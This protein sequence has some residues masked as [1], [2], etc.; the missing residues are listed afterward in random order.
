MAA[1]QH[2]LAENLLKSNVPRDVFTM[3]A[4]AEVD[5]LQ[6]RLSP[7]QSHASL[8]IRMN[9][10]SS[11]VTPLHV[12][13][14][15]DWHGHGPGRQADQVEVAVILQE[16]GADLTALATYRGLPDVN[17]LFC[18]C[19]SSRNPALVQWLLAQGVPAD[20]SQLMAA[21]GHYQRH[22]RA[23]YD[24]ADI[25]LDSGV[26]LEGLLPDSRTALQAFA[27]QGDH[28]TVNWLISH[29]ANVNFRNAAGRMAVHYAAERLTTP[30]T[31]ALLVAHG[32]DLMAQ[33]QD[34]QTPMEIARLNGKLRQVAWIEQRMQQRSS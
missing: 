10:A 25:L 14:A 7:D 21:L 28:R 8:R 11:Q 9:P 17:P 27:H 24:I 31:L 5:R 29:G 15:S 23:A 34:G 3:S 18:A 12:A 19:W 32:A 6:R 16:H 30:K 2:R 22:G 4:M 26:P 20:I 33:D 13:C 1:G